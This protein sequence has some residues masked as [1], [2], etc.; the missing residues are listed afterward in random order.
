MKIKPILILSALAAW[1]ALCAQTQPV[2]LYWY[3]N[4][5]ATSVQLNTSETTFEFDVNHLSSGLHSFSIVVE[6]NSNYSSPLTRYFVKLCNPA[7]ETG[8]KAM[9]LIDGLQRQTVP[10]NSSGQDISFFVDVADLDIGLHSL[11]TAIIGEKGDM[12]GIL[13]SFFFRTPMTNEMESS[14]LYYIFDND[15]S[16]I[17]KIE[18]K[19][20]ALGSKLDIDAST[21]SPGLHSVTVYLANSLG[22]ST[23]PMTSYFFKIPLGGEGVIR[24]EYWIDNGEE[25]TEVVL[26]KGEV[27]FSLVKMIDVPKAAFNSSNFEV[28]KEA[29][30]IT[31]Y[32]VHTF[33]FICF[34]NDYK[35][36]SASREYVESRVKKPVTDIT[37]LPSKQG[38]ISTGLVKKDDIK[39]Y[40]VNMLTGDSLAVRT[41][42]VSGIDVFNPKGERCYRVSGRDAIVFGGFHA[43]EEGQYLVAVHDVLNNSGST[44]LRYRHIDK[45]DIIATGPKSTAEADMFAL[46]LTGQGIEHIKSATLT[47]KGKSFEATRIVATD[48]GHGYCVFDLTDA[49]LTTYSLIARFDDG[50]DTGE[51][52]VENVLRV[53][54]P[55]PGEIEVSAARSVF[56]TTLNDV[57]IKVTN[58]GN[59]PYWGI[60]FNIAAEADGTQEIKLNFKDFIPN[61]PSDGSEEWTMYFTDN[62]LGTGRRGGFLP[63]TIPYIG[64][65]ETREYTI[66]Y[67]MPLRVH[68]PTYV[69]TG[70]PWSDEFKELKA[71][72]SKGLYPEIKN[73]NYL[74]ASTLSLALAVAE[75]NKAIIDSSTVNSSIHKAPGNYVDISGV[76]TAMD[77]ANRVAEHTG[78][79]LTR[80]N[81][82]HSVARQTVGI[83]NTIGGIINAMRLR[84]LDARL[85]AYGIDLSSGDYSILADYR[86]DLLQSIPDPERIIDDSFDEL[87]ADILKLIFGLHGHS[88]TTPTPM[89]QAA[90]IVQYTPCDPNDIIGYQ[91]PSGGRYVGIGVKTI[92]YT[93]EFENDPELANAPAHVIKVT[94]CLDPKVFDLS[95]F[96]MREIKIGRKSLEL[97]DSTDFVATID[98]RP[99]INAA[100]EVSFTLDRNTGNAEWTI[101]S[102]DLMTM[103]TATDMLQGVLPVNDDGVEGTGEILFDIDLKDG[104]NSGMTFAN[105]ASIIFDSND[106]IET[107]IWENVIDYDTP[108]S[109]ITDV[110]YD[111]AKYTFEVESSDVGAGIWSY[112]LWFLPS[113]K[114]E[115]EI[116]KGG[117]PEGEVIYDSPERLD[118]TFRIVATDKAGNRQIETPMNSLL[119]DANNNGTVEIA[120][121]TAEIAY[122]L[123]MKPVRFNF[124]NADVNRDEK[125]NVVDV[126]QT[127]DIILSA[128]YDNNNQLRGYTAMQKAKGLVVDEVEF[129]KDNNMII[130]LDDVGGITALQADIIM[131]E[132]VRIKNVTLCEGVKNHIISFLR[133][134][135]N[136]IRVAVYSLTLAQI[137]GNSHVLNIEL[138]CDDTFKDKYAQI[139]NIYASTVESELINFDTINVKLS[140]TLSI[141]TIGVDDLSGDIYTDQGLLLQ[142]EAT[143]ED[144]KNLPP[145]VYI[146]GGKKVI[147]N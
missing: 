84:N 59:V 8:V 19:G 147:V 110:T 75:N 40:S 103:E 29:D 57:L 80:L 69:W 146:I 122:I 72:V 114:D 117:I 118:G 98:M 25:K 81:D 49:P 128:S 44:N 77:L 56:G 134:K 87:W 53:V 33:N 88:A 47:S 20:N 2:L 18:M 51:V 36:T 125:I 17:R 30:G 39:W 126:S 113:D 142:R 22:F 83:G 37:E 108:E 127:V 93:I 46:N 105:S 62:L 92:P 67:Q 124:T 43:F 139:S 123:D 89:P 135:D 133:L 38:T 140:N 26:D 52:S 131:P 5:P 13:N 137:A 35:A 111:D 27:P 65:N 96:Q 121:V 136:R 109:K 9:V 119:G 28:K 1:L 115:W 12:T 101:R 21:L 132:G 41:D 61:L 15:L 94:D 58:T 24:Y 73:L 112:E 54:A 45:F 60:P 68:I 107:P 116:L 90:D 32:G 95:S 145:G 82:V 141:D 10:I 6:D 55:R 85:E 120:D 100:A 91:D 66:V 11:S 138:E 42:I 97:K 50:K 31:A 102:L 70:R 78:H 63:M 129:G 34:D 99:E 4:E 144:I 104:L 86:S 130:S 14:G 3:D 143:S 16:N 23:V 79:D 48:E 64:P 7:A 71:M 106:A 76:N 74:N